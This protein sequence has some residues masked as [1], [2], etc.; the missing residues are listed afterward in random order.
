MTARFEATWLELHGVGSVATG[1]GAAPPSPPSTSPSRR[2]EG[3][4]SLQHLHGHLPLDR[5]FC[6]EVF[7]DCNRDD[8]CMSFT[9]LAQGRGAPAARRGAG[10]DRRHI[11][12]DVEPISHYRRDDDIS[13][14]RTALSHGARWDG[15]RAGTWG[16][17]GALSSTRPRRSL[18]ARAGR[19][20]AREEVLEHAR[21]FRN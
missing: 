19:S 8:L 3:A 1:A 11:A 10:P 12:F 16:D 2:R 15:R 18:P 7:V 6:V 9:T 17:A 20:S 5:P 21:A 14:S 13:C 4:R